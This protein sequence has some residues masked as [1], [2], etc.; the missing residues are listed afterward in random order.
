MFP[1]CSVVVDC[2]GLE[3]PENGQVAISGT[4][5]GSSARYRCF[6]GYILV[7]DDMRMCQEN[8]YW[9]G[10][11]PECQCKQLQ[12]DRLHCYNG[13]LVPFGT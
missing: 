4:D 7:G 5:F 2:G 11:E 13:Q 10:Q 9:S 3:N 6:S 8:G 1:L 12:N